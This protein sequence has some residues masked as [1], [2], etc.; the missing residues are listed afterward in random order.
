MKKSLVILTS[1]ISLLGF[2]TQTL[3]CMG[4]SYS[5][6]YAPRYDIPSTY[7]LA[8][9]K[10]PIHSSAYYQW[11]IQNNLEKIKNNQITLDDYDD[12]AVAYN[13]I[14]DKAKAIELLIPLVKENPN[15]FSSVSNLGSIYLNVGDYEN[16]LK[17]LKI[18]NTL[19]PVDSYDREYAQE[20]VYSYVK[21]R[22]K[23]IPYS[24]PIQDIE[25][26]KNFADFALKDIPVEKQND[27]IIRLIFGIENMVRFGNHDAPV[28]MEVLGDLYLK[29]QTLNNLTGYSQDQL[30]ENINNFYIAALVKSPI[31]NEKDLESLSSKNNLHIN[32][33]NNQIKNIEENFKKVK[34][35]RL[36]LETKEK[37]IIANSQNNKEIEKSLND[38]L[39][40]KGSN[41]IKTSIINEKERL[42]KIL[43]TKNNEIEATEYLNY[44]SLVNLLAWI[45]LIIAM[46]GS[47]ILILGRQKKVKKDV[48]LNNIEFHRLN[49]STRYMNKTLVGA[50]GLGILTIIGNNIANNGLKE[51]NIIL[52]LLILFLFVTSIILALYNIYLIGFKKYQSNNNEH[53]SSRKKMRKAVLLGGIAIGIFIGVSLTESYIYNKYE[54]KTQSSFF[55]NLGIFSNTTT[56]RTVN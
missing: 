35:E 4:S 49:S 51:I 15:R 44:T 38:D 11:I 33:Y 24:F 21:S 22:H 30:S 48:E 31:K 37:E 28:S 14:G 18:A 42:Y 1:V 26:G 43:K 36:N 53:L 47:V 56:L 27:E 20:K 34:E 39:I 10:L 55:G 52:F 29:F 54:Y 25:S 8:I 17:Y 3:A 12:L 23:T 50:I 7:D 6:T 40:S 5:R 13:K 32:Y 19:K 2:T 16:G 45:I 9:S 41:N 46:L